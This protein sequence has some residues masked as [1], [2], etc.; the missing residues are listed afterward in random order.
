M[1]ISARVYQ[2][3]GVRVVTH[4]LLKRNGYCPTGSR[5]MTRA[6]LRRV[7][8]GETT[9]AIVRNDGSQRF[10]KQARPM[11]AHLTA[12]RLRIGCHVWSGWNFLL[13]RDWAMGAS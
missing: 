12:T 13:L 8:M 11:R 1:E 9:E 4:R 7:F 10:P 2:P 6:N 5:Y 3:G